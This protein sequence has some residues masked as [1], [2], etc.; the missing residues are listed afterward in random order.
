M[1]DDNFLEVRKNLINI[2]RNQG[3][4]SENVLDAM[5]RV[6][7]ECF[8]DKS[9]RNYAYLNHP[10]P[11]GCNQTISQPYTVAF[12]TQ[13]LEIKKG[14]KALEIGT[15]SGYQAAI[16]K[17]LGAE[18]FSVERI[19]SL[20]KR[21]KKNLEELNYS[22]TLKCGDG[23]LGWKEYAPFDAILV[24][25]GSPSIPDSLF[26]QLNINGVLVIPVGN[27]YSQEIYRILKYKD[28]NG[29]ISKDIMTFKEFVFV[30][31]IGKE[32]WQFE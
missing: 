11:I 17:E 24:T 14:D 31:L 16:L 15:G 8:V 22:V 9:Q 18:V 28:I 12:M 4:N 7:R 25:A 2:L 29:N 27:N 23:T 32:G 20:Y 30:P 10:L 6:K 21:A 26:E 19:E 1:S 5:S 13:M 3:I